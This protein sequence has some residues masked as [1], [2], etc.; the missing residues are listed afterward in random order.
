MSTE[1]TISFNGIDL[2]GA[3]TAE[4]ADGFVVDIQSIASKE[5]HEAVLKRISEL[6]DAELTE[7][8]E[9]ELDFL[10][11]L[12]VQY[13]EQHYK[14]KPP[15]VAIDEWKLECAL[16]AVCQM[17]FSLEDALSFAE[18]AYENAEGDIENE[19]PQD[20]VDAETDYMRGDCV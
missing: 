9:K 1:L 16:K 15:T 18:A 19:S 7:P 14:I 10:S 11:T 13:E 12:A 6:M 17:H 2:T 3:L 20:Y 8:E 4:T 5:S